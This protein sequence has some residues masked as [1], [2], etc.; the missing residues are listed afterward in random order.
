MVCLA[1][2]DVSRGFASKA[3]LFFKTKL[4]LLER[5]VACY[6]HIKYKSSQST[7]Y[8]RMANL[9]AFAWNWV[10]FWL[11]QW[12]PSYNRWYQVFYL[13]PFTLLSYLFYLLSFWDPYVQITILSWLGWKQILSCLAYLLFGS[14]AIIGRWVSS[15]CQVTSSAIILCFEG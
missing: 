8:I 7:T 14:Y 15:Y 5:M 11:L 10:Y 3:Q 6:F 13:F 1:E 2:L 12:R 4:R 9:L